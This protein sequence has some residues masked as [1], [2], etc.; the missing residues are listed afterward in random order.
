MEKE[1]NTE[2]EILFQSTIITEVIKKCRLQWA[3]HAWRSQNELIK[4]LI[5]QNSR[6]KNWLEDP[7]QDLKI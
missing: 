5:E 3:S 4:A 1:K 7:K 6:R 2:L